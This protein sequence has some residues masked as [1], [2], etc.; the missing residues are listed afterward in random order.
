MTIILFDISHCIAHA[1]KC[2]LL[3]AEPQ[4]QSW[5]ISCELHG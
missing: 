2:W 4:I 5:V 1:I 3:M